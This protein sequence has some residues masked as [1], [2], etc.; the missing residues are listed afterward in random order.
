MSKIWTICLCAS[1][2]LLVG[3]S[4]G[5]KKVSRIDSNSVTD[6]SGAW[7]DTDSRLVADEMITDCLNRPWYQT[8]LQQKNGQVPTVVIGKVRNK[9][10]E[11]INVE[12]F[13]KDIER[14]LINS[15]KADFV[16]NA[17][18]RTELRDELASQAGNATPARSTPSWTRKVANRSSTTRST[19]NSPTSRATRRSG[20][21]TRKSRSTSPSPA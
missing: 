10:H 8:M 17:E 11:H 19:W 5:G 21:A 14:A 6:L 18:E 13:I 7:N 3:C 15:G 1:L 4:S 20:S 9:S 16:A 12:T 2:A